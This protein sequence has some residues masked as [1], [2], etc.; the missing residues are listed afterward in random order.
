VRLQAR[1]IEELCEV[2]KE[3]VRQCESLLAD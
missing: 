3:T 1:E 2:V